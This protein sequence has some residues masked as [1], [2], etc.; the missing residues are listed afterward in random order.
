M[1]I[2]MRFLTVRTGSEPEPDLINGPVQGSSPCLNWTEGSVLGS[3][4][5]PQ[6]PDRTGLRQHY[7]E[8][9]EN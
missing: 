4:K 1:L 7:A 8:L 9:H 5:Y 2:K 3:T 6:E